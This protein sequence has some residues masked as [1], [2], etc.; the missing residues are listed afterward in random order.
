M[1]A[2]LTLLDRLRVPTYDDGSQMRYGA[3]VIDRSR[4]RECG[5]CVRI[6]PG[7]WQPVRAWA[8]TRLRASVTRVSQAAS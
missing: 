8:R 4:C 1:I 5:I 2:Q 3:L 7:A 6:C